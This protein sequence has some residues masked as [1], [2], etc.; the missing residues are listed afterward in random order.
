M[1][2]IKICIAHTCLLFLSTGN[3]KVVRLQIQ[4]HFKIKNCLFFLLDYLSLSII[5]LVLRDVLL[6]HLHT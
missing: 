5:F 6:R 3:K 4:H 2:V 1:S